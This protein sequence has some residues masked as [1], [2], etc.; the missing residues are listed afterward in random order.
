MSAPA[1]PLR[2]GAAGAAAAAGASRG[3]A[4][5]I[6]G[7]DATVTRSGV[8]YRRLET[9]FDPEVLFQFNQ[10]HGS[11][12]HNFIPEGPVR[13]HLGKVATGEG[14]SQPA[15]CHL[16]TGGSVHQPLQPFSP[17]WFHLTPRARCLELRLALR[18]VLP[19]LLALID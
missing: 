16:R 8:D 10:E 4:T 2:A 3:F 6:P 15:C 13:E 5:A 14:V 7:A 18:D 1:T 19:S 17:A 12:P 11:T 9:T